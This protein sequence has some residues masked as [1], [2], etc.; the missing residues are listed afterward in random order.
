MLAIWKVQQW[1]C[2]AEDI[3]EKE[4]GN[5]SS[6]IDAIRSQL[7]SRRVIYFETTQVLDAMPWC[8]IRQCQEGT[9]R[10]WAATNCN[11]RHR[12]IRFAPAG[13]FLA[14]RFFLFYFRS[15]RSLFSNCEKAEELPNASGHRVFVRTRTVKILAAKE[16]RFVGMEIC[17]R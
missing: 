12:E 2:A 3:N 13:I 8:C 16:M 9:I 10:H 14:C 1:L 7:S 11:L 5:L 6:S 17:G 15:S 4:K